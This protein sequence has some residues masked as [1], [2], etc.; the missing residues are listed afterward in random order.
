M[1]VTYIY[2]NK[3]LNHIK[4]FNDSCKKDLRASRNA[5]YLHKYIGYIIILYIF[6]N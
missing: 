5:I 4:I 3:F 6:D 2:L 1:I